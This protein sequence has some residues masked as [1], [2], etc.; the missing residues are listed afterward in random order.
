MHTAAA[1]RGNVKADVSLA[2]GSQR[3]KQQHEVSQNAAWSR[4][5]AWRAHAHFNVK[6]PGTK[7]TPAL[8]PPVL[9]VYR[10]VLAYAN[11]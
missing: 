1:H 10:A 2:Q 9:Q 5:D 7:M 11:V 8:N 6:L 3:G 4:H